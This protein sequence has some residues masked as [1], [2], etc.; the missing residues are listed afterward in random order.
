MFAMALESRP[1]VWN[2]AGRRADSAAAPAGH[3]GA[4]A[5]GKTEPVV[6]HHGRAERAHR[7]R[8]GKPADATRMAKSMLGRGLPE[9]LM[10]ARPLQLRIRLG[11]SP[12]T[13]K[14]CQGSQNGNRTEDGHEEAE[15]SRQARTLVQTG[16]RLG[17]SPLGIEHG[18]CPE[19]RHRRTEQEGKD[20]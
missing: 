15:E 13:S 7:T 19:Q 3:E 12:K 4:A 14:H 5:A 18:Y 10:A 6:I 17:G 2:G 9:A 1:P 11:P 16:G 20:G 8:S